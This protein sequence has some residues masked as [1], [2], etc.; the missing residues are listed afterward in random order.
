[1]HEERN[2][3][4]KT[5]PSLSQTFPRIELNMM[6]NLSNSVQLAN[7]C[8]EMVDLIHDMAKPVQEQFRIKLLRRNTDEWE[9]TLKFSLI[10]SR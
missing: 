8:R 4:W 9:T 5:E 10:A 1:L 3:V 2:G 7:I 6:S